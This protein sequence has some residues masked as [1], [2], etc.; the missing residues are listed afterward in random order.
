MP[1][2]C[3]EI[4]NKLAVTATANSQT[5]SRISIRHRPST[6]TTRRIEMRCTEIRW[7]RA[8]IFASGSVADNRCITKMLSYSRFRYSTCWLFRESLVLRTEQIHKPFLFWCRFNR[9]NIHNI[10]KSWH[11]YSRE[12]TTIQ[13]ACASSQA[14][15]RHASVSLGD[16][17][18]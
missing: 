12:H 1:R 7:Q 13:H 10:E 4:R 5:A 18:T 17:S 14:L 15:V 16:M 8:C 11:E 6:A 9:S 3:G 2:F